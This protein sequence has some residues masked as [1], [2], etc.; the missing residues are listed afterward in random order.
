MACV[1]VWEIAAAKTQEAAEL[2]DFL[3]KLSGRQV[4]RS[5][6]V[7]HPALLAGF[8]VWLSMLEVEAYSPEELA[9]LNTTAMQFLG[10]YV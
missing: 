8:W 2:R 4:K 1:T 3:M 9:A 10:K 7:T 6:P 5:K